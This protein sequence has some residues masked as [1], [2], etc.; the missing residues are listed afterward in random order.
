LYTRNKYENEKQRNQ[1]IGLSSGADNSSSYK[2]NKRCTNSTA[3]L[4]NANG[5]AFLARSSNLGDFPQPE[6]SED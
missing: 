4:R 6:Q 5:D 2:S 3:V 1:T